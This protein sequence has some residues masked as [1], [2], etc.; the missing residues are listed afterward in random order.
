[1]KRNLLV[2]LFAFLSFHSSFSQVT[3]QKIIIDDINYSYSA[4]AAVQVTNDGGYVMAGAYRHIPANE[5]N[6]YLVKTNQYGDTLWTKIYRDRDSMELANAVQQTTDGGYILS[7]WIHDGE[8]GY[9]WY[10]RKTD[11]NGDILWSKYLA[12]TLGTSRS[13]SIIQTLDGGYIVSGYIDLLRAGLSKLDANG[14]ITWSKQ[15]IRSD[16]AQV[17][18]PFSVQQTSDSG[19][20]LA[21]YTPDNDPYTYGA[22]LL[23]TDISGNVQWTKIYK[24]MTGWAHS[25]RQTNDG[26]YILTGIMNNNVDTSDICL[27]KT[28]AG[29]VVQWSKSIG[30]PAKEWAGEVRQ[31]NDN[32][33]IIAGITSSFGAGEFDYY[34]NKTDSFGN[35]EWSKIY[36]RTADLPPLDNYPPIY[37][38]KQTADAGYICSGLYYSDSIGYGVCLIKTD[39]LGNTGCNELNTATIMA[40]CN[41]TDSLLSV[42]TLTHIDTLDDRAYGVRSDG[43]QFTLCLS[44]NVNETLPENNSFTLFPN[45]AHSQS[46][47]TFNDKFDAMGREVYGEKINNS[48]LSTF[49]FELMPGVYVVRLT[50][51]NGESTVAKLIVD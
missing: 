48:Q 7:G 20:I 33:Y 50:C 35:L 43:L 17:L 1:M 21:G 2:I 28:D 16:S 44:V 6:S 31:T 51:N 5:A 29:G 30:G 40:D 23:K 9:C 3:F 27:I 34:L 42:T 37:C 32:G 41:I 47:I 8:S 14:N 26:G 4:A 24:N 10:V 25:A 38:V 49:N 13:Y 22:L 39:S 12:G 45:P 36:G 46:T 18:L 19:Y 15:Y 11:S